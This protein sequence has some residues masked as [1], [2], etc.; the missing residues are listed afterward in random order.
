MENATRAL[1]IAAG[2]L[3]G[4]MIIS[5]AVVLFSGLQSYVEEYRRQIE[6]NELNTFNNKYQ[7]YI[8]VDTANNILEPLTIQDIVTVA[9]IAYEDNSSLNVNPEEWEDIS[10]NSLYVGI[11]LDGVRI[12]RTI[13]EEMQNLLA[14]SIDKK[15]RCA[16]ADVRYNRVGKIYEMHFSEIK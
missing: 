4:L 16:A 2:V 6:F 8:N 13:K 11:F 10:E 1:Y 9:G 14:Q 15:Y 12:D 5:L 3:I 7:K